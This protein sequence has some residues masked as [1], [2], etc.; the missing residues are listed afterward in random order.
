MLDIEFSMVKFLVVLGAAHAMNLFISW[1]IHFVQHQDIFGIPL[2]HIH[3]KGHH[4]I[5]RSR[6]TAS[7][8]VYMGFGYCLWL[9]MIAGGCALYHLFFPTWMAVTFIADASF[10]ALFAYYVHREYDKPASWLERFE[11]FNR[12]RALHRIHHSYFGET[13]SRS[14]NYA[15]GGPFAGNLMDYLL[16]TFRGHGASEDA[17]YFPRPVRLGGFVGRIRHSL[18]VRLL[19]VRGPPTTPW[20][21]YGGNLP[22]LKQHTGSQGCESSPGRRSMAFWRGDFA[23]PNGLL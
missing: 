18:P 5:D 4:E 10:V 23:S 2:H 9:G 11:W 12:G 20:D 21:D 16:G 14:K 7:Q 15:F 22:C 8:Y 3:L 17:S 13:F 1:F 19:P 6:I